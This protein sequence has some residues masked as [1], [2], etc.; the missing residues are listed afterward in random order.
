MSTRAFTGI[1]ARPWSVSVLT[2]ISCSPKQ[3]SIRGL[4]AATTETEA[5]AAVSS[6]A[7]RL[8]VYLAW[9]LSKNIP[10]LG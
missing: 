9:N 4:S 6:S 1:A 8:T 5:T 10:V 3:S 2:R 7:A